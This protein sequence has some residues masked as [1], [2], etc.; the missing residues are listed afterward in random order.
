MAKVDGVRFM[1][2]TNRLGAVESVVRRSD[3]LLIPYV[4]S[5]CAHRR[6]KVAV[7]CLLDLN[8]QG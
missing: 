7:T 5:E 1:E 3:G 4:K 6:A 2:K 8:D